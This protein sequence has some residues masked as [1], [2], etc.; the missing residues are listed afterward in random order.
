M[1]SNPGCMVVG[2]D[3]VWAET[4]PRQ[5]V[6][7]KANKLVWVMRAK[8][9]LLGMSTRFMYRYLHLTISFCRISLK[10]SGIGL[11]KIVRRVKKMAFGDRSLVLKAQT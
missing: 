11:L 3:P 4:K 8:D 2:T 9:L 6:S 1:R 5:Q 7:N 10:K